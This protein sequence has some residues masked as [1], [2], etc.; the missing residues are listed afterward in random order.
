MKSEV[1]LSLIPN[2]S[3]AQVLFLKKSSDESI[4]ETK[5][6]KVKKICYY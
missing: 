4:S 3:L 5:H 2:N 1:T 6:D